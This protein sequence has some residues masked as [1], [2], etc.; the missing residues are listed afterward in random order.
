MPF[1]DRGEIG[2]WQVYNIR[3]RA[4]DGQYKVL[5]VEWLQEATP[6]DLEEVTSAIKEYAAK[7]NDK[8]LDP[9][10]RTTFRTLNPDICTVLTAGHKSNSSLTNRPAD[11]RYHI[12]ARFTTHHDRRGKWG[13]SVH[14]PIDEVQKKYLGECVEWT[15]GS[16][17]KLEQQEVYRGRTEWP[18]GAGPDTAPWYPGEQP[19]PPRPPIPAGPFQPAPNPTRPAWGPGGVHE[20]LSRNPPSQQQGRSDQNPFQNPFI[21][22]QRA[23]DQVASQQVQPPATGPQTAPG[24]PGEATV[25]PSAPPTQ[26]WGPG[27]QTASTQQQGRSNQPRRPPNQ[28]RGG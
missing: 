10:Y 22:Q 14:I 7:P 6:D 20:Q 21:Q 9:K 3:Y 13:W 17:D 27:G 2:D 4:S 28:P 1:L 19:A 18:P 23:S 15:G 11:A 16:P 25:P 8:I 5:R 24:N 12:S 26:A